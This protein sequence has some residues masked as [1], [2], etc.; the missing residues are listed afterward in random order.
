MQT[1][2]QAAWSC[3]VGVLAVG[4]LGSWH[5]PGDCV[6][7]KCRVGRNEVNRKQVD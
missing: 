7:G 3:P 6:S 4:E 1:A 5:L 2:R